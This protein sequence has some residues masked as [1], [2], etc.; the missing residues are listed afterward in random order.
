[1]TYFKTLNTYEN[2]KGDEDLAKLDR[3]LSRTEKKTSKIVKVKTGLFNVAIG[4]I[5]CYIL[6][7]KDEKFGKIERIVLVDGTVVKLQSHDNGT[8]IV[9]VFDE[10]SLLLRELE[11]AIELL[12]NRRNVI[13]SKITS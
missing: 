9:F 6:L 5:N 4:H 8:P 12:S 10:E 7:N 3:I 1:M 13:L 2:L 11:S